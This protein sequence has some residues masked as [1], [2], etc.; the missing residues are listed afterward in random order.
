M[1]KLHLGAFG[2][3]F[4]EQHQHLQRTIFSAQLALFDADKV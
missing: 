1:S 4:S 3:E 2:D